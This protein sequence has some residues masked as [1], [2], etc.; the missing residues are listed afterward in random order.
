MSGGITKIG[1]TIKYIEDAKRWLSPYPYNLL[2]EI[3]KPEEIPLMP[4]FDGHKS[5]DRISNNKQKV[6]SFKSL[7]IIIIILYKSYMHI[8]DLSVFM[9]M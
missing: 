7:L 1:I 3:Y 5:T 8:F 9:R 6:A 2:I 4:V